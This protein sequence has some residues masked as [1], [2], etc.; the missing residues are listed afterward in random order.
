MVERSR[1]WVCLLVVGMCT[2]GVEWCRN[3]QS[4]QRTGCGSWEEFM[5]KH[6]KEEFSVPIVGKNVRS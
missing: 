4:G 1:N 6:E 5:V 2:H 3:R